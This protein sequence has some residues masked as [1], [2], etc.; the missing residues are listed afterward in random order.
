MLL[1]IIAMP[2]I[3]MCVM[4]MLVGSIGSILARIIKAIISREREYLADSESVRFVRGQHIVNVLEKIALLEG[5]EENQSSTTL[6]A[7]HQ[8]FSHFYLQNYQEKTSIFDTHPPILKR[9]QK[10][11]PTY[12]FPSTSRQVE[13]LDRK[14]V[15]KSEADD[16]ILVTALANYS[17]SRRHNISHNVTMELGLGRNSQSIFTK[18]AKCYAIFIAPID[19]KTQIDQ[20]NYLKGILTPQ[21]FKLVEKEFQTLAKLTDH[22][23]L[24]LLTRELPKFDGM[25]NFQIAEIENI[26]LRLVEMDNKLTIAEYCMMLMI[27]VHIYKAAQGD[28]LNY[29]VQRESIVQLKEPIAALLSV[30]TTIAFHPKQPASE[31]CYKDIAGFLN[32]DVPYAANLNWKET[33]D[34]SLPLIKELALDDQRRLEEMFL[35]LS[36]LE[37]V[38][39]EGQCILYILVKAFGFNY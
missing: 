20:M 38:T 36:N 14:F 19:K 22:Q 12:R 23:K 25:A 15:D 39:S 4:L 17:E 21:L 3:L 11:R 24:E 35:Q 7:A 16:T 13:V 9:I 29:S 28:G 37:Q 31:N 18:L 33:M 8:E 5:D 10:I 26:C 6:D 1:V 32:I 34:N 30:T 2:I 27:K